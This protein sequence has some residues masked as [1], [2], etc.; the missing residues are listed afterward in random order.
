MENVKDLSKYIPLTCKGTS[1]VI[2]TTQKPD[3][4]AITKHCINLDI[5]SFGVDDGAQLLFKYLERDSIDEDELQAA[6]EISEFVEGLP[7]A[8]A[9]IGGYMNQSRS[10]VQGFLAN[11][12]RSS[13][14]WTASAEG[15]AAQ[16]DKSLRTVFDLAI[17]EIPKH[18]RAFLNVLAF[19]DPDCIPE[20]IFTGHFKDP[21]LEFARNEDEYDIG[22]KSL[23]LSLY[24]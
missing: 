13:N 1:S 11:L 6:E 16:Y 12:K 2:M 21:V 4:F 8:I 19:L 3:T 18:T 24:H 22:L 5:T 7:L 10:Q 23:S 17:N 15:P 20:D 9:A 14:V